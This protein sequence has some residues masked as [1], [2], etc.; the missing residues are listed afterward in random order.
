MRIHLLAL[1]LALGAATPAHAYMGFE[2]GVR[3]ERLTIDEPLQFTCDLPCDIADDPSCLDVPDE[4]LCRDLSIDEPHVGWLLGAL[5]GASGGNRMFSG[6]LRLVGALGPFEPENQ[7]KTTETGAEPVVR[8]TTLGHVTLEAPLEARLGGRGT[9]GFIQLVPRVGIL[10]YLSGRSEDADTFTLGVLVVGGVRFGAADGG[11][12]VGAG[13]V[14]HDSF[15]G[16]LVEGAWRA[17]IGS[18]AEPVESV[19]EEPR[20]RKKAVKKPVKKK[21]V[22]KKSVTKKKTT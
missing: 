1:G 20:P 9:Y 11:I 19:R 2:I 14:F 8:P 17:S 10:N 4:E 22:K 16:W 6:G 7:P 18:D 12:A 21:T 3:F 5:V 13:P 15:G